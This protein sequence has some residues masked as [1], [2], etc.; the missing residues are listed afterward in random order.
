MATQ[1]ELFLNFPDET[2]LQ[3][4]CNIGQAA[5]KRCRF[6]SSTSKRCSKAGPLR[7]S[8]DNVVNSSL[9]AYQPDNCR[10]TLGFIADNQQALVGDVLTSEQ[11]WAGDS[12]AEELRFES[13]TLAESRVTVGRIKDAPERNV[14][15][16]VAP[17]DITFI[18]RTDDVKRGK[19]LAI[20]K[21]LFDTAGVTA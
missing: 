10:G 1:A 18:W 21:I 15:V 13:L 16:R 9:V 12:S 17:R 7:S 6:L 2:Q 5:E 11:I 19:V 14:E 4:V 3:T 20:E 8:I